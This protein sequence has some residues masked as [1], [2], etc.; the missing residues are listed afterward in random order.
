ML[1][2][3][4]GSVGVMDESGG[5]VATEFRNPIGIEGACAIGDSVLMQPGYI[6]FFKPEVYAVTRD[7]EMLDMWQI[8]KPE[9]PRLN[10]LWKGFR[11]RSMA[12]FADGP[13]YK[14]AEW[15]DA[16]PVFSRDNV[17]QVDPVFFTKR[18]RDIR[19]GTDL[20]AKRDDINEYPTN[21][22]IFSIDST[23]RMIVYSRLPTEWRLPDVLL[24]S[25]IA[26]VRQCGSV[27]RP[28][29]RDPIL[30]YWGC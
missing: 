19:P 10:A 2:G 14:Y 12:C 17:A 24:H 23:V 8:E 16:L 26:V 9:F 3:G 15:S 22:G 13:Y 28:N 18:D 25:G 30:A 6:P 1:L 20:L 21:S 27:P 29:S 7:L 5:C 4:D 11:G